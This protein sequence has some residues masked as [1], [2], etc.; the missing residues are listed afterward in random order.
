MTGIGERLHV[1]DEGEAGVKDDI[2]F[3]TQANEYMHVAYWR[4]SGLEKV[5]RKHFQY[6]RC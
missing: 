1:G 3:L 2:M 5:R 4:S 6:R